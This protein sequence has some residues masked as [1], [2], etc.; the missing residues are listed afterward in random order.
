MAKYRV[1]AS[2]VVQ[3]E[4]IV[5]ANSKEEALEEAYKDVP[6]I[7][8]GHDNYQLDGCFEVTKDYSI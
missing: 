7:T 2:E 3:Y 1:L 5:E 8:I 6:W 4:T